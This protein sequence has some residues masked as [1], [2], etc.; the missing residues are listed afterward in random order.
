M[1]GHDADPLGRIDGAAAADGD[2][3]VAALRAVLGGAG[4]DQLDARVGAHA[5]EDDR[6]AVRT[7][8]NLERGVQQARRFH[9][10]VGDEQRPPDAQQ[11]GLG[12]QLADRAQALDETG[13]ALVGAECV[14]QHGVRRSGRRAEARRR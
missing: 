10:R 13:R 11:P 8:Q 5:I 2:E 3:A 6:L 9:P 7:A 4:V 12:P 14:F 1:G